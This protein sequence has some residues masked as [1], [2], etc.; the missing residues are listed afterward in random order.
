MI[1]DHAP[2]VN[3]FFMRNKIAWAREIHHEILSSSAQPGAARRRVEFLSSFRPRSDKAHEAHAAKFFSVH[4]PKMLLC[5][6]LVVLDV[7]INPITTTTSTYRRP[8]R[9]ETKGTDDQKAWRDHSWV[10]LGTHN[11]TVDALGYL[12]PICSCKRFGDFNSA[13]AFHLDTQSEIYDCYPINGSNLKK[14]LQRSYCSC[15]SHSLFLY[16]PARSRLGMS[17]AKICLYEPVPN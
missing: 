1:Q 3:E 15:T 6:F 16:F 13:E 17:G 10:V 5:L 12:R 14:F 8:Q 11:G 7:K 9:R 2:S 4:P